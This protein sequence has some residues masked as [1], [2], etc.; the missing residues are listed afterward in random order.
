M[1]QYGN[2]LEAIRQVGGEKVKSR[3][4]E[5]KSRMKPGKKYVMVD[6]IKGRR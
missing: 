3:A 1:I 6:G 2:K 4:R 5:A